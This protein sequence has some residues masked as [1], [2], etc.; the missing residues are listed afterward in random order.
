[1]IEL[2]K[3]TYR[4][5]GQEKPALEDIDLKIMEGEI[6]LICGSSGSG[7]STL[8]YALNG[9]IPH[10]LGGE[11]KGHIE[12]DGLDPQRATVK[13]LS[14]RVGTV[15][16][17]PGNQIFMPRVWEDA[18]FGCENLCFSRE[19]TE[20]RTQAALIKMGLEGDG[21]KEV[22]K[23]SGGQRKRL[24]IAGVYAMAPKIFLMD[25][26]TSDLDEEGRKEFIDILKIL[27]GSGCTIV[28]V[29]HRTEEMESQ[30]DRI[31]YL[32]NGR[33]IAN[34]KAGD[35]P[36]FRPGAKRRPADGKA[37]IELENLFFRYEDESEAL[38][39][40]NLS[41]RKGDLIAVTG[42]NGS[43]KTTLFKI[44]L[45][46]RK[47]SDGKI[48]FN[49]D[50][51]NIVPKIGYLFQNPDEQLFANSVE[52]EICFG[53]NNLKKKIDV[54]DILT[55]LALTNHRARHPQTLS[56]GERQRLALGAILAMN[57]ET[58][59]L[60]E[61][62]TGLDEKNWIKIMESVKNLNFEGKTVIFSTHNK[63]V[64]QRYA[65]RVIQLDR[66]KIADD[67]IL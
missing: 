51:K 24:A 56:R 30:V 19:V 62:T 5:H 43:G 27:K 13:E 63:K 53:P 10:V 25:E 12:I 7:K 28:L 34:P 14:H 38:K 21:G 26:P 48:K 42:A 55:S 29:E 57:P 41:V 47:P 58:I 4:Y 67:Q 3:L 44:L 22:C 50:F 49:P 65:H 32:E 11:L 54:D 2:K 37:M 20:K 60:D 64:V 16:Q 36:D 40:I 35:F 59:I 61:P 6:A 18:A 39:G 45:G 66:G 31:I 52:E 9:I 46:L 17:N 23:L 1:M 8:L 33:I 15:F